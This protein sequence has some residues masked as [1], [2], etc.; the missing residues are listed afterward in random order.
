MVLPVSPL[1]GSGHGVEAPDEPELVDEAA[2]VGFGLDKQP[3]DGNTQPHVLPFTI[4][5]TASSFATHFLPSYD[6]RYGWQSAD[7]TSPLSGHA[8][9]AGPAPAP[10]HMAPREP[11]RM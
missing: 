10:E 11:G 5:H 2:G 8:L 7:D 9:P 3:T 6:G 1:T 4:S